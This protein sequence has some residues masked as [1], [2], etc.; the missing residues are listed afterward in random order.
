MR[1][2]QVCNQQARLQWWLLLAQVTCPASLWTLCKLSHLAISGWAFNTWEL[3][4]P[5]IAVPHLHGRCFL[6]PGP[7]K[8]L[9]D[10]SFTFCSLRNS[11]FQQ[12]EGEGPSVGSSLSGVNWNIVT[13]SMHGVLNLNFVTHN[14]DWIPYGIVPADSYP[15][16]M[17]I[18]KILW[19][20]DNFPQG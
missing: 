18:M 3:L 6:C 2:S 10:F 9:P 5:S 13:D 14:C 20:F 16:V 4:N 19:I 11:F 7:K 15:D 1:Q 17:L 12:A 8:H